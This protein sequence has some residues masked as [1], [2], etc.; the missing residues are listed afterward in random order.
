M[1]LAQGLL[2]LVGSLLAVAFAGAILQARSAAQGVRGLLL[3]RWAEWGSFAAL[4]GLLALL[5]GLFLAGAYEV[6][7]VWEHSSS[8]MAWYY[9]FAALWAGAEGSLLL[10]TWLVLGALLLEERI[11][12]ARPKPFVSRQFVPVLRVVVLGIAFVF[13]LI[14][15][16]ADP[17]RQTEA[18]KLASPV[19]GQGAG[20]NILLQTPWM[21]IHPPITFA[22]YAFATLTLAPALAHLLTGEP[23]WAEVSRPWSRFSWVFLAAAIGIGA[24]WA[25]RTLSFAGYWAWDAVETASL[26]PWIAMTGFLHAQLKYRPRGRYALL[27]PALGLAPLLLVLLATFVTR[28]PGVWNSFHSFGITTG[29]SRFIAAITGETTPAILFALLVVLAAVSVIVL[30]RRTRTISSANSE[31]TTSSPQAEKEGAG[32]PKRQPLWAL[33]DGPRTMTWGIVLLALAT[34]VTLLILIRQVGGAVPSEY[35]Q[36]LLFV[37]AP[38]FTVQAAGL[39]WKFLGSWRSFLLGCAVGA[40][41]ILGALLG[42][43]FGSGAAWMV[44]LA[45]PPLASALVVSSARV[46]RSFRHRSLRRGLRGAGAHLAHVGVALALLGYGASTF[47][48]DEAPRYALSTGESTPPFH[49]YV[50]RLDD[51]AEEPANI[52]ASGQ[53]ISARYIAVV[54]VWQDGRLIAD[55]VPLSTL[56]AVQYDPSTRTF[57]EVPQRNDILLNLGVIQDLYLVAQ[58]RPGTAGTVDLL[59]FKVLPLMQVMWAGFFTMV[60]GLALRTFLEEPTSSERGEEPEAREGRAGREELDRAAVGQE[61]R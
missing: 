28:A 37:V 36:K 52:T 42:A 9:Q 39:A 58:P 27:A 56:V 12:A 4:S 22:G 48:S 25:Y 55:G 50:V 16:L 32:P 44:G 54:S 19:M 5:I 33:V 38:L 8:T 23:A 21:I 45:G 14:A 34:F 40:A 47:F 20:L 26:L 10:W 15:V 29:A 1:L 3:S 43:L 31:R 60:F 57:S 7:Y 13:V 18:W 2:W 41:A 46:V 61:P 6:A 51:T 49:G 35:E 17:F 11:M 30:Q 59:H 24:L 53:L